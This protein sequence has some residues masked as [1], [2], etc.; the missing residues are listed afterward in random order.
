MRHDKITVPQTY[1]SCPI[2]GTKLVL[3]RQ[4]FLQFLV[5]AYS[6]FVHQGLQ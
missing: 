6:E 2:C 3:Y 5:A 1:H 4:K